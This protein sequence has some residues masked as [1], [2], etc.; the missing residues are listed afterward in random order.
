MHAHRGRAADRHDNPLDIQGT[1]KFTDD[2]DYWTDASFPF[3]FQNLTSY[4][5]LGG[6]DVFIYGGVYISLAFPIPRLVTS[7]RLDEEIQQESFGR[8]HDRLG[9]VEYRSTQR[10]FGQT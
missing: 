3:V 9:G 4:F 6:D 10:R 8:K 5:L 7:L 2:I 1:I